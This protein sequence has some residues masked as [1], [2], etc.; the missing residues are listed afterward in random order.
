MSIILYLVDPHKQYITSALKKVSAVLLLILFI[1]NAGGYRVLISYQQEKEDFEFAKAL[2]RGNYN[3]EDLVAVKV[4]LNLPYQTG[5][6]NFVR[7][8]GE[9]NWNGQVYNYVKRKVIN[10][11]IVLLCIKHETKSELQQIVNDYFGNIN[12]LPGKDSNK[13]P[14]IY[15][16]I[17][18]DY[19]TYSFLATGGFSRS[20]NDFSLHHPVVL[21]YQYIPVKGEP[22][23]YTV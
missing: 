7:V 15:R 23:K 22:P 19:D 1:F 4:P 9:I 2:D 3:D 18:S 16:Q 14:L 5:S 10:D 21:K 20:G 11:T 12:D 8:N 13:K 6:E 17:V